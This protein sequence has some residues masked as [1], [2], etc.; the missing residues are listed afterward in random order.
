MRKCQLRIKSSPKPEGWLFLTVWPVV[1]PDRRIF[2]SIFAI[3]CQSPSWTRWVPTTL[4]VKRIKRCMPRRPWFKLPGNPRF[5]LTAQT[6]RFRSSLLW[7]LPTQS[8]TS[9]D[10]ELTIQVPKLV[11]QPFEFQ[12][13]LVP[14]S[15]R[16]QW[17]LLQ[18]LGP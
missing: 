14:S 16:S 13:S 5:H 7:W 9:E 12:T 8:T 11:C 17:T 18:H 1:F 2:K 10:E 15:R 3:I 4:H 6:S